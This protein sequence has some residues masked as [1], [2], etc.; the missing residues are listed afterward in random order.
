MTEAQPDPVAK[1]TSRPFAAL[2][3]LVGVA[4]FGAVLFFT[5]AFG[6]RDALSGASA[7]AGEGKAR[8]AVSGKVIDRSGVRVAAAMVRC[9]WVVTTETGQANQGMFVMTTDS[10][11]NYSGEGEFQS[12]SLEEANDIKVQIT[13]QAGPRLRDSDPS[14]PIVWTT[15]AVSEATKTLQLGELLPTVPMHVVDTTGK[16]IK[17][18][19]YKCVPVSGERDDMREPRREGV[20]EDGVVPL[21]V[22][23]KPFHIKVHVK[24]TGRRTMVG[25][26]DPDKMPERIDVTLPD[27]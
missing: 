27:R 20:F 17:K 7:L 15:G 24:G 13:L 23:R 9:E 21:A 5:N 12:A 18:I 22:P 3:I 14:A 8:C 25:P 11:G 10:D 19:W 2:V 16:P 1:P 6:L 26:F 4:A